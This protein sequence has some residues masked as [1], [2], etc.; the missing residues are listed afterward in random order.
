MPFTPPVLRADR[1]DKNGE[2][3][4]LLALWILIG[5]FLVPLAYVTLCLW[6][7]T[8]VRSPREY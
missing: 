3:A 4:M 6:I 7:S 2:Q 1:P 5:L 8:T